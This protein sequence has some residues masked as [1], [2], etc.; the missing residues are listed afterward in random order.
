MGNEDNSRLSH[1]LSIMIL[2]PWMSFLAADVRVALFSE[3]GAIRHRFHS[4]LRLLNVPPRNQKPVSRSRE[5]EDSFILTSEYE[6]DLQS[7]G[8]KLRVPGIHSHRVLSIGL[9]A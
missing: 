5:S 6:T 8:L 3:H 7:S 2:L 9:F 4:L 1:E